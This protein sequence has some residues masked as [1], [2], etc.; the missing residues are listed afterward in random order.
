MLPTTF[1][2]E[3][4]KSVEVLMPWWSETW[5]PKTKQTR[6]TTRW[7]RKHLYGIY[8]FMCDVFCL[9]AWMVCFDCRYSFICPSHGSNFIIGKGWSCQRILLNNKLQIFTSS[10][11]CRPWKNYR[12]PKGSKRTVGTS[13]ILFFSV[14][15]LIFHDICP[16]SPK[17]KLGPLVVGNPLYGSFWRP[18]LVWSL[19][20]RVYFLMC[21]YCC[22]GLDC[23]GWRLS[24]Y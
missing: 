15:L 3:P 18:F 22:Q 6:Q 11:A 2:Q 8:E 23:C 21:K 9:P 24:P 12:V 10:L 1:F 13:P 7:S 4:L 16:G 20:S 17:T 19:T 5:S 14:F